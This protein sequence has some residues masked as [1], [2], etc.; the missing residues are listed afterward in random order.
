MGSGL[1]RKEL[2]LQLLLQ[3]KGEWVDGTRIASAEVGGSEGL[4]RLREL[5]Q[6]GHDIRMRKHPDARRDIY[7]YRLV[8]QMIVSSAPSNPIYDAM[9]RPNS[10]E[11]WTPADAGR[12]FPLRKNDD[13]SIEIVWEVCEECGGRYAVRADHLVGEEH[14][15]WQTVHQT[16]EGQVAIPET[17]Q[18][19]IYKYREQPVGVKFGDAV[20]CP[21]CRG[22]RRP[23]KML[24]AGLRPADT[25]CMDPK[26]HSIY[27]Q[28]CDGWG[29][30]PNLGPVVST[31]PP[32]PEP[33]KP[34]EEAPSTEAFDE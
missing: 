24:K 20:V 17:P 4:K 22:I 7:Q 5:R 25:M 16:I 28:R 21:R 3:H 18:P 34:I 15:R 8:T 11:A 9:V 14:K 32:K 12:N 2:V 1:T 29:I 33:E 19:P 31:A 6:D 10:P 23:E 30:V 27:C 13:G 26:D